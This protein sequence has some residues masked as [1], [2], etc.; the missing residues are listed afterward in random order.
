[1]KGRQLAIALVGLMLGL[2]LSA[3][4]QTIVGTALPRIISDLGGIEHYAWV[5]TAYLLT[6]TAAVPIAGKLSDI[7]GRKGF[8]IGGMILFM[9]GS[10]L[11][12][13]SQTMFQLIMFRGLQGIAGGILTAN[14][15][16]IIGDLFPPAERGK[17]QGLTGA[18]FGIASVVGPTLGGWLTDGPG[19]RWV[20][21]VNLP[22]GILAVIVLFIGMPHI[23]PHEKRP[24]DWWGAATII[25]GTVPLLLAFSWGGTEY[26]WSSPTILGLL[27]LAVVMTVGFIFAE[28]HSPE[29]MIPLTF[30]RN[31]IFTVSVVSMFLVGAAML[32][33]IIYIPLFIQAV[34]GE[35]A[36]NSGAIL[37]PMMLALVVASIISGQVI[38]R[39]GRYKWVAVSGLVVMVFGM[40]LLSRMNVNTSGG[41]AVR[42]MI[43]VGVGLGMTMPTFTISVQ[44]AFP[45]RELGVVTSAVQFFR[46]IGGT[47]GIALMGTF[48]TGSLQTKIQKDVPADVKAAVPTD[49]L[50]N[51]NP[52]VLASPEAR[53]ALEAQFAKIPDGA[54]L[55]A[56]MVESMRQ[57]LATSFHQVFLI[58]SIVGVVAVLTSLFLKDIPLRKR[59]IISEVVEAGKELAAE[60]AAQAIM[61][62]AGAEPRLSV[63]EPDGATR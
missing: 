45:A 63:G 7:Y 12:G 61:A 53:Q 20:F 42:D 29:P 59:Q 48:L 26:A 30:F 49:I 14:A 37:T 34:I 16:A 41:T 1:L 46:S 27:A 35:S 10:A 51:L 3:L 13:L 9:V 31:R 21:Y 54:R 36:T 40:W 44:N 32:G 43:V 4:D 11:C 5:A 55:F 47:I 2:L 15:F 39:S 17:W 23:R 22:V 57:A 33:S 58:S 56:E 38:S 50:G 25:G 52:Q 19:W 8:Y 60:G 28:T 6:S 18:V 24:I 62:P